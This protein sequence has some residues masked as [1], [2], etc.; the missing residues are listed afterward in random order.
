LTAPEILLPSPAQFNMR[1]TSHRPRRAESGLIVVDIQE[2]LLPAIHQKERVVENSVR[3]IQGAGVLKVPVFATEQYRK[4]LG[5][6]VPEVAA[7]LA[8]GAPIEKVA[9]S[10]CGA[11]GFLDALKA[12]HV[13]DAIL[14]GIEAHVCVAQTGLDLLDAGLRVFV[15]ADAVSSRT[16]ENHRLGLERLRDCGAALVSTEMVLFELLEEAGTEEFKQILALVR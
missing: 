14:C 5:A 4:G 8:G 6:T 9:F 3:L 2:R 1:K 15:V 13:S 11:P 10:A 12:R 16:P 7:A